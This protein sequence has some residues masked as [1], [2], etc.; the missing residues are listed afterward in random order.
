MDKDKQETWIAATVLAFIVG[1]GLA[2]VLFLEP[3][4]RQ[5]VNTASQSDATI[6]NNV[7]PVQ[8]QSQSQTLVVS[9]EEPVVQE[10]EPV[11]LPKCQ[12]GKCLRKK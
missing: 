6:I 10:E 7:S 11:D 3:S 5:E 1:F 4:P 2:M 9:R 8:F 12:S